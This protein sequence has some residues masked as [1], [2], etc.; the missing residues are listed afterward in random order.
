MTTLITSVPPRKA[1]GAVPVGPVGRCLARGLLA[2]GESV[3]VLCAHSDA[4]GWPEGVE[5]IEGSVL[6]PA[7]APSAF[8]G[9]DRLFLAGATP[10]VRTERPHSVSEVVSR[11][12][13]GGARAIVVLSSHG[14]VFA[15]SLPP[16]QWHWLAVERAVEAS[17]VAWTH[18]RPS[19]VM[20]S[21]LAGGYP[22]TGSAWAEVIRASRVIREPY[23]DARYPFIDEEDLA[24]VAATVLFD[25]GY[26]GSVLDALGPA[27][28]A[29]QRASLIAEAIGEALTF[30]DL[31]PDEARL[32]WRSQGW[33][34][35]TIEV[36]LWAQSQ[37]L[38]QPSISDPTVERVLGRA[39]RAFAD[40]LQR[41][42]EAFS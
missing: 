6:R 29:R 42:V 40:W 9:I 38:I 16:E 8:V 35:E 4:S 1:P 24:E 27:I 33:P 20:A 14:P 23:G 22:P 39:P 37:F 2:R 17:P 41:H 26:A 7:E 3:R 13:E 36:T 31:T 19:A 15:M 18:I 34:E 10:E 21:M 32:L 12:V 25:P 11:A 5:M 28:S 30:E